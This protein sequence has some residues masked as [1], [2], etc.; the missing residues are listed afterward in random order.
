M[1]VKKTDLTVKTDFLWKFGR[2]LRFLI[3]FIIYCSGFHRRAR[4]IKGKSFLVAK[5]TV[6]TGDEN[7]TFVSC[8]FSS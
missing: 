3:D 8:A 6:E 7:A 2:W 1:A 5:Y 4:I